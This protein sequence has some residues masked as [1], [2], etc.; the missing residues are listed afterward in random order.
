MLTTNELQQWLNVLAQ[1]P[2][3]QKQV[4]GTT[5]Q[6]RPVQ[7][8]KMTEHSE[9]PVKG[10]VIVYGRQHPPEIP[11]YL[12][13]QYFLENLAADTPLAKDFRKYFDV[14]AFPLMNPDGADNGHW[15]TNA[16][17]IDLNRDWQ[18]FNQPET[19]AAR[20]ALLPLLNRKDRKVFYGV[21]FHSTAYNVLYPILKEI[22]TFP[23]HFTYIWADQIKEKMP[24][25]DLQMEPFDIDSP[26]AKNWIFKTFGA[27]AVTFEVG[28]ETPR[29]QLEKLGVRAAEI[30]MAD[31]IREYEKEFGDSDE[32]SAP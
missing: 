17:G 12:V 30:F 20:D 14:W 9:Q 27:D 18:H 8:V 29:D 4:A 15:R 1:K 26:I 32:V 3:V 6:G 25:L 13:S 31:M 24:D 5:H 23:L 16:A 21:D 10:V 11:G 28:D 7:L 22:D 2:F 19:A